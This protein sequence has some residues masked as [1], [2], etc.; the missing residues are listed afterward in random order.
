MFVRPTA[1]GRGVA[2]TIVARLA[3]EARGAGLGVLKLETGIHQKAALRFYE[4]YGFAYCGAFEPYA[5][6]APD[7]VSTSVFMEMRLD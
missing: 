3:D 4:R 1:R 6:M 7:T 5:A 2:D